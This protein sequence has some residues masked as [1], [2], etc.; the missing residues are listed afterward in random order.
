MWATKAAIA[1]FKGAI[2]AAETDAKDMTKNKTQL[3]GAKTTLA[4]ARSTFAP[5]LGTKAN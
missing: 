4:G 3:D 1:T 5:Q 2:T